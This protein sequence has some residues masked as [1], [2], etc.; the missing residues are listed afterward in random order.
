MLGFPFESRGAG[1][2]IFGSGLP[3]PLDW[4]E[5]VAGIERIKIVIRTMHGRFVFIFIIFSIVNG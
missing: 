2:F 1:P 4:A 5:S 3:P